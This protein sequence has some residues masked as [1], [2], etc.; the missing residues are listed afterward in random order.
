[1]DTTVTTDEEKS[2]A[3]LKITVT[4]E[5]LEPYLD[6]VAKE[7]SVSKPL[8]G[9][10]PGKASLPVALDAFGKDVVFSEALP[11]AIPR[12]FMQAVVEH[13]IDALGRPTTTIERASIDEGVVFTAIVDVLPK[14]VLGDLAAVLAEKREVTVTTQELEQELTALAKSRST[15]VDVARP[16]A[17]GDTVIVDFK[18]LLN[19][20]LMAGGASKNHPVHLGEGH[21]VPDFEQ[22]L[23]GITDNEEREFTITFPADFA[24][25]ELRSK[26]AIAQVKAHHVQA[27]VVP[28][29]TDHF[30]QSVGKFTDMQ[31]LRERLR[32][33]L[34]ADRLQR[35]R[36]RLHGEL[37]DNLA[38]SA[39]FSALPASLIDREV[40]RR[41]AELSQMLQWQQKTIEEYLSGKGQA[42]EQL[43]AELRAPAEWTVK[44]SLALRQFA[45]ES[46]V[47][48]P[49]E[50]VEAEL[51]R[52]LDQQ[53]I[54]QPVAAEKIDIEGLRES[55]EN[56][57]RHR[58]AL[59]VLEDKTALTVA[60]K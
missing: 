31:Q 16:A 14:V 24:N 38:K 26:E 28:E 59:Q 48:V 1:M 58:Q 55:I 46:N 23:L 19:G 60:R 20:E 21:F 45:F 33:N 29:L 5:E 57:L 37:T 4:A 51:Q 53:A 25:Q 18:V 2:Q 10:R 8:K 36:E 50:E 11:K 34:L 27:R 54:R 49:G 47:V 22:K 56:T 40:D 13:K 43:R 17:V 42:L 12:W 41:V 7:L 52:Y 30:A 6:R 9:F 39:K 3:T 15:Y 32:E 44:V 35:E